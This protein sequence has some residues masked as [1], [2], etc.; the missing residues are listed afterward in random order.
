MACVGVSS[1]RIGEGVGMP[2]R[3]RSTAGAGIIG[4]TA[5]ENPVLKMAALSIAAIGIFGFLPV[6]WTLPSEFLTGTAAAGGIALINA[7][8]NLAGFAGPVAM[9]YIKGATG[10]F[11]LGLIFIGLLAVMSCILIFALG[12]NRSHQRAPSGG[13][14]GA[15]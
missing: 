6:F 9:G 1:D 13:A 7:I 15:G 2:A 4:S 8:G 5:L 11:S 12:F 14:S 10:S 3:W